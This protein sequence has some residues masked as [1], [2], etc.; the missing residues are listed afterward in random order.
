MSE[1]RAVL[2]FI[3]VISIHYNRNDVAFNVDIMNFLAAYLH[4]QQLLSNIVIDLESCFLT[5]LSPVSLVALFWSL[6][7]WLLV[8]A[9][10][11]G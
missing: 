10:H 2:L 3:F 11:K 7:C 4:P 8:V 5:L 1:Y 9:E 6:F